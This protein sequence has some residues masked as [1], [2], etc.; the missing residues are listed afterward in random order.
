MPGTHAFMTVRLRGVSCAWCANCKGL[1]RP[2][3]HL[4]PPCVEVA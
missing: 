2:G 3:L 4:L 1:W